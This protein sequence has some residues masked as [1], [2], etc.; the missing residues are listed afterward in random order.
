MAFLQQVK[1][2][3]RPFVPPVI[4]DRLVHRRG[5][6][7]KGVRFEGNYRTWQEACR[8]ARGYDEPTILEK[9]R[10]AALKV[11]RGEAAYERDTVVFDRIEHSYPALAGL[12]YAA[13][14]EGKL[15]VL[16]F[17]GALGSSYREHKQ[18]LAHIRGLRWSIVEQAHFTAAGRADF[19]TDVLHF[20]AD[21]DECLRFEAP[22]VLLLSSVLQYLSDPFTFVADVSR[23]RIPFVIVDRT[24]VLPGVETRLTVQTVPPEIYD[25]SY[26]AWIFGDRAL[27]NALT[28]CYDVVAQFEAHAGTRIDLGDRSASYAGWLLQLRV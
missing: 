11:H 5:P 22:N 19:E 4:A 21:I 14:R 25:A 2:A 28:R 27:E 15:S 17:G 24:P 12:L 16:D 23:H 8:D 18:F 13:S 9:A 1:T 10:A 3:L 20:Y 26:P 7:G 6:V